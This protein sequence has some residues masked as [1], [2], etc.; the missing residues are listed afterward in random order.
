MFP[1]WTYEGNLTY[2]VTDAVTQQ[3]IVAGD[4]TI[5]HIKA[6]DVPFHLIYGS[7]ICAKRLQSERQNKKECLETPGGHQNMIIEYLSVGL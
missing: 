5:H 1:E 6:I 3:P 4:D 2:K 7:L